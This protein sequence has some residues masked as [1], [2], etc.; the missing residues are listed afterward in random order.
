MKTRIAIYG[1]TNLPP[2]LVELVRCLTRHLLGFSDVVLLSSGFEF[3]KRYP[4]RTSVDRAVLTEVEDRLG[5]QELAERFETW[6]PMTGLDRHSVQRFAKGT[7]HRIAGTAQAMRF[8][9]VNSA[10]GIVTIGGEGNT[11]AVLEL[12]LAVEKPA[13]PVAFTGG[14]SGRMWKRDREDFIKL[15]KLSPS[16]AHRLSQ[17]PVSMQES[18]GLAAQIGTAIHEAAQKRC[19]VLMPFGRRHDRFYSEV[20]YRTIE[21]LG[22][23][24]HRIDKDDYAGNI[25]EL[26]LSA[27]GRARA[28]VVDLTDTNPNVMYELGQVHAREINPFLVLRRGTSGS[29]RD[30]PFYLRHERI[31]EV[32]EDEAGY[33]RIADE[34]GGYLKAIARNVAARERRSLL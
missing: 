16:L 15:L 25:P 21:A 19:L 23:I 27:L 1:G 6:L 10:D 13:L 9:L 34:L 3:F 33:Q 12:A 11:R 5:P 18:E 8:K 28:V 29:Y 7:V 17:P 20:L 2:D 26:F 14:D 24:P 31:V 30:L 4:K 32:T 22:Y